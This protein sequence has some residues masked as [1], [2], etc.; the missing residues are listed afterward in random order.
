MKRLL[1]MIVRIGTVAGTPRPHHHPGVPMSLIPRVLAA[2][3]LLAVPALL[4]VGSQALSRPAE[5]PPVEPRTVVVD[6]ARTTGA[7]SGVD[8]GA[9]VTPPASEPPAAA[10]SGPSTPPPAPAPDSSAAPQPSPAP[11]PPVPTPVPAPVAPP[12]QETPGLVERQVLGDDDGDDGAGD[13]DDGTEDGLAPGEIDD[14][15]AT[16]GE[17]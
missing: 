15:A 10:P 5:V 9:A 16:T 12:Q 6:L 14:D 8:D 3:G 17:D 2:G 13:G 1:W 11:V 4:A 7:G